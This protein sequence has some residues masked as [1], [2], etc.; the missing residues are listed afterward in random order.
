LERKEEREG[1]T[2]ESCGEVIVSEAIRQPYQI[3]FP[4][5]C[6][7][8]QLPYYLNGNFYPLTY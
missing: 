7:Y 6:S 1:V 4:D 5:W 8:F 3:V 2:V